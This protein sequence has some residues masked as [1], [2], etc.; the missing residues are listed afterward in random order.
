MLF[1]LY[2]LKL[3]MV[4]LFLFCFL[5]F[6]GWY[7]GP[8]QPP[9]G[10]Q[11][12]FKNATVT[13]TEKMALDTTRFRTRGEGPSFRF[14]TMSNV[15]F[16]D[17]QYVEFVRQDQ[18]MQPRLGL[19]MGFE[20]DEKNGDYPYTPAH[21]V[22]QLKDFGYGGVEFSQRDTS[23]FT[24]VSDSVSDDISIEIEGFK[25]DTILGALFR[26][27]PQRIRSHDADRKRNI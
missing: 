17:K 20:F 25:N 5:G 3:P 13:L 6:I 22:M 8:V 14:D 2:H 7:S 11:F 19:A 4:R 15:Y 21:A 24:G 9:V 1:A 16:P 18:S 27:A 12:T 23:N 10:V 26:T